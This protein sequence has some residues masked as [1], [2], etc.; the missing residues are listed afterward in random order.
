MFIGVLKETSDGE[1]RVALS[2]DSAKK[3]LGKGFKVLIQEGAGTEASFLDQDFKQVGAQIVSLDEAAKA[4]IVLKVNRPTNDEI[5]KMKSG[6]LVISFMEPYKKDGFFE[7]L[8][9]RKI[10]AMAM[11]L[12]P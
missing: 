7:K 1:K 9:E 3:L 4:D 8:A 6:G 2:P 12:I 10:N 11:E 5:L